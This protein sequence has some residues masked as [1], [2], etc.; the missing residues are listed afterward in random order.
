MSL[1][2]FGYFQLVGEGKR[3]K[4]CGLLEESGA[5]RVRISVEILTVKKTQRRRNVARIDVNSSLEE[6]IRPRRLGQGRL[7]ESL[8]T[9]VPLWDPF[10][11]RP[12]FFT[13][14]VGRCNCFQ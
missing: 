8:A 14:T 11:F 1:T 10:V 5:S 13:A 12:I 9:Q 2:V 3:E 6:E 7:L 4:K